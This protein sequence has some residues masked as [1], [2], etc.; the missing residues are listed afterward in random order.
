MKQQA[1]LTQY[2]CNNCDT[3]FKDEDEARECCRPR[4]TEVYL[5]PVCKQD[6][7]WEDD[8]VKHLAIPHAVNEAE[9]EIAYLDILRFPESLLELAELQLK[10]RQPMREKYHHALIFG[11][12]PWYGEYYNP[13]HIPAVIA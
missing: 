3:I 9:P 6:F 13:R 11:R 12:A 10:D 5:C 4:I 2:R 7:D 8:V 1:Y